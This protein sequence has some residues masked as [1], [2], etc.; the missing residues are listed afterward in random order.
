MSRVREANLRQ[1]VLTEELKEWYL[2]QYRPMAGDPPPTNRNAG[3]RDVPPAP[4][5]SD[6]LKRKAK[7][8]AR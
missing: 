7:R 1:L 3:R 8:F 4:S 2:E 5:I 6:E